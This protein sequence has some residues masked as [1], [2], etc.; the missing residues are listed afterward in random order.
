VKIEFKGKSLKVTIPGA[1]GGACHVGVLLPTVLYGDG[2][3]G[4]VK[5]KMFGEITTLKEMR[6]AWDVVASTTNF[7]I[8]QEPKGMSLQVG[9][10]Y[11]QGFVYL[12]WI[13]EP[14]NSISELKQIGNPT[15]LL[16]QS[17]NEVSVSLMYDFSPAISELKDLE[18]LKARLKIGDYQTELLKQI[19]LLVTAGLTHGNCS[20]AIAFG[21]VLGKCRNF[22]EAFPNLFKLRD[23]FQ[24]QRLDSLGPSL[25]EAA[26]QS[27][28]QIEVF[29][30]KISSNLIPL[31]ALP[32]L[33]ILLFQFSA[34]AFYV[35]SNVERLEIEDASEWS[36]LLPGLAF[37]VSC[38]GTIFVLSVAAAVLTYF[39]V[40]GEAAL[41][42]LFNIALVVVVIS[43]SIAAF[44][45]VRSLRSRVLRNPKQATEASAT[46]VQ[47]TDQT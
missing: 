26:Q 14:A 4:G 2:D 22:A 28:E 40:L 24:G 20:P 34:V 21:P 1:I 35:V 27:K 43:S 8:L 30:V 7:F 12:P 32:A 45:A 38:F 18:P 19:R 33:A 15:F 10:G 16:N 25:E 5:A 44:M 41:P 11:S 13:I 31:F 23:E 39:V 47:S 9:E 46:A 29:G 37:M 36:L 42:N 6:E 17:N 3:Y